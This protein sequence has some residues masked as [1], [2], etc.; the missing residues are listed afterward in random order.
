MSLRTGILLA[1]SD[2]VSRTKVHHESG[3]LVV[4]TVLG[5]SQPIAL[6]QSV[7]RKAVRLITSF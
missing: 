7:K 5:T 6:G 3:V 1:S 2:A 4:M